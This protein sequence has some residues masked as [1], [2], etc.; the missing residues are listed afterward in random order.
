MMI[1]LTTDFGLQDAFVGIMK[2]V[3]ASINPRARVVDLT[4]GIPAQNILAGGLVLR[5]A[6]QYFPPGTIHVAVV[7]PGVGGAR[8]PLLI[9]CGETYFIG[10]DNGVLS[11]AVADRTPDRIICLSNSDYH[12]KPTS[13][14]FHGRDIFAPAAAH[15]SLGV[16]ASAF[17]ET[18]E[19]LENLRVPEPVREAGKISAEII[20][21][22]H[23]GNLFTNIRE[24]DLTLKAGKALEIMFGDELYRVHIAANYVSTPGREFVALRNSWG[25]LE[26]A[27]PWGN[28][29]QRLSA[30]IGDRIRIAIG[31]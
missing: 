29:Q 26:I 7:D 9:Q 25:V 6:V 2:G 11:P 30:K 20:Y 18:L 8:R 27:A 17:G 16:P 31:E 21:I 5:H 23:F 22:D 13:A 12:L 28:A 4:H 10:P 1:T 3:I 24:T 14:T 19:T 15:V